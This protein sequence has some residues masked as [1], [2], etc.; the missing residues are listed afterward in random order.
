MLS[1]PQPQVVLT[2]ESDL[3]GLVAGLLLRRLA[4]ELFRADV[5]LQAWNYQGWKNRSMNERV[6]WVTDFS[7]EARIDR[8]EWLVV[9]HHSTNVQPRQAKLVHDLS[10]SAALLCYDLCREQGISSPALD[11]LVHLT[12]VG[13][14]WLLN[15]P[16]FDLACDYASL[17]KTY[18]FWNL[19]ALIQG[20]L[21][22]LLDHPLLEVMTAKRRIEDPIGYE[23]SRAHVVEITPTIG[24]VQ[25]TVGNT[26]LIVH[27][28]L[29]RNATKHKVLVTFFP[30]S[31]RTVVVSFR[32]QNGEALGVAS[33]LQGGGHANAA[34]TTLPKSVTDTDTAM[35][36]LR[37]VLSPTA[38]APESFNNPFAG[39]KL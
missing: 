14:L 34:G 37:Q 6:A 11:R 24:L 26:N 30:K 21:E 2:H 18:G 33:L 36:Y 32:S 12:N 3:D 31:N 7:F 27:Q 22:R 13:D 38:M 20:N 35:A 10:K 8:P 25:T 15:D 17:V 39:F 23:W 9:D 4:R 16:D 19:H 5:P 1:L 29:E 28:L